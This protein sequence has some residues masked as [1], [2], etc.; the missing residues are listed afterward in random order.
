MVEPTLRVAVVLSRNMRFSEDG[1]TAIDLSARDF[2]LF[3]RHIATLRVFAEPVATPFPGVDFEGVA[4]ARGPFG[5]R[6]LVGA[7]RRFEPDVVVVHHHFPTA[8]AVA[9]ALDAPVVFHR[10]ALM[11]PRR[12]SLRRWLDRRALARFAGVVANSA[13]NA[14]ALRAAFPVIAERVRVVHN[15][16]DLLR[17]APAVERA[18]EVLFVGRAHPEKGAIEAAEGAALALAERRD[19]RATFVL[20]RAAQGSESVAAVERALRPLGARATILCNQRHDVARAAFE[21]A[22]IALSPSIY[23]EAFGRVLIEAFA[24]GAAAITS[25]R[26]ALAEVAGDAALILPEVSGRGVAAALGSLIDDPARRTALARAGRARCAAEFAIGTV[27]ARRD[28]ALEE[29]A[30]TWKH[31]RGR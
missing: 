31:G 28:A 13:F 15:G 8:C 18:R 24:G 5:A 29:A 21:R 14:D 25:G 12:N 19:W 23:G 4:F 26:G 17:W 22:A 16:L 9:A 30:A 1:A 7:L 20:S 2:A 27:A 10:H 11:K 6:A 3:S